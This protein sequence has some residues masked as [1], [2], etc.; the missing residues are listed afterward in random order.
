M[1]ILLKGLRIA[2]LCRYCLSLCVWVPL[3]LQRAAGMLPMYAYCVWR[4]RRTRVCFR[5]LEGSIEF[6]RVHHMCYLIPAC[7]PFRDYL[8]NRRQ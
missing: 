7:R 5:I 6:K 1:G 2:N 4:A 3:L 8:Y